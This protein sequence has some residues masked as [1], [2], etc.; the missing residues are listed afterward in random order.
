MFAFLA[1]VVVGVI[2]VAW[3]MRGPEAHVAGEDIARKHIVPKA[4]LTTKPT[5]DATKV[6]A[7]AG[8][9][10]KREAVHGQRKNIGKTKLAIDGLSDYE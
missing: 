6:V 1:G 7:I 9:A 2:I 10:K 8:L 3:M 4:I 5:L